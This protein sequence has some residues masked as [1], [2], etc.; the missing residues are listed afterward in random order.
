MPD[1]TLPRFISITRAI[2]IANETGIPCVE[3]TAIKW[4]RENELGYQAL[5]KGGR[6]NVNEE[7]WKGFLSNGPRRANNTGK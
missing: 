5:G 4:V 1:I 3:A 7:L 2:E 6:W